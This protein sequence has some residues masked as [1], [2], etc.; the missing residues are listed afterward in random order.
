M[1]INIKSKKFFITLLSVSIILNFP[2][3]YGILVMIRLLN[4]NGYDYEFFYKK[5]ESDLFLMLTLSI[6]FMIFGT[7]Y[8]FYIDPG[9]PHRFFK[10]KED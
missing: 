9:F 7:F 2:F 10:F 3:F 6:F 8:K 4:F 5:C 1:K